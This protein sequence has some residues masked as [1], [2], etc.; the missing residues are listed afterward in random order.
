[1]VKRAKNRR[2]HLY[3]QLP[4]TVVFLC[5]GILVMAQ[6]QTNKAENLSLQNESSANLAMIMKSVN[7]NK[8]MLEAELNQLNAQLAETEAIVASGMSLTTTVQANIENLQKAVGTVAVSG[9]G[10]VI[11]IAGDSN[12][13]YYDLIDLI[14]ELLVSG[15]E[16]VAI[17]DTRITNRSLLS[18]E[19]TIKSY[20]DESGRMQYRDT[21][22]ILLDGEELLFPVIIK[23]IG[24]PDTLETGLTYPGGIIEN[25]NTLYQVFPTI[26]HNENI[27]IPAAKLSD[28]EYA[29]PKTTAAELP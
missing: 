4:M 13:M 22:V 29:S 24:N 6:Y 27:I 1:M 5:F 8:D 18:E 7:D 20:Y 23:A 11:T 2:S 15:A 21:Y 10:V 25:L 17:N 19:A 3:W 14:N 28:Y 26:K 9:P 16:A 12:L